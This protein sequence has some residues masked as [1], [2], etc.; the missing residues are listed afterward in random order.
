M[1]VRR[2]EMNK[3]AKRRNAMF[4]VR[5]IGQD[6]SSGYG[7]I[8]RDDPVVGPFPRHVGLHFSELNKAGRLGLHLLAVER[9]G[10]GGEEIVAQSLRFDRAQIAAL[11]RGQFVDRLDLAAQGLVGQ[12]PLAHRLG[13]QDFRRQIAD[14]GVAA[15]PHHIVRR[16]GFGEGAGQA[17]LDRQGSI[18]AFDFIDVGVD[19]GDEG[20]CPRFRVLRVSGPFGGHVAAIEEQARRPVLVYKV[21][22]ETGRQAA[23]PALAP[24]I[25]LPEP[26]AGCVIP[27]QKERVVGRGRIDMRHPPMIDYNLSRRRQT[28]GLRRLDPGRR[29]EALPLRDCGAQG[30]GGGEGGGDRAGGVHGRSVV[31]VS[32]EAA[33]SSLEV[34]GRLASRDDPLRTPVK[35]LFDITRVTS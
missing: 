34:A 33:G 5:I 23:E 25:D 6:R 8:R 11:G 17:E 26:V 4:P 24:K 32:R 20:F 22:A 30:E 3:I 19:P 29:S 1:Q 15:D 35:G 9:D 13:A 27:L 31:L 21:R 12:A 16:P 10:G 2:V 28:P 18:P 7:M 14:E